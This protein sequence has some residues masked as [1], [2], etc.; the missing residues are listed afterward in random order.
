MVSRSKMPL[1][2]KQ[3]CRTNFSWRFLNP[4]RGSRNAK[5]VALGLRER[6]EGKICERL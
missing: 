6:K 2:N 1:G 4:R 3:I 5:E